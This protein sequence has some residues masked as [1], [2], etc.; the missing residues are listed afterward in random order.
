M[1]GWWLY[2]VTLH[3]WSLACLL[4]PPS[5]LPRSLWLS[6]SV[7]GSEPAKSRLG[8][9]RC[10]GL[11]HREL[12]STETHWL[13]LTLGIW[14]PCSAEY[15]GGIH[16]RFFTSALTFAAAITAIK[17]K[18]NSSGTEVAQICSIY[19]EPRPVGEYLIGHSYTSCKTANYF[20]CC[21]H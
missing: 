1:R 2:R 13:H 3:L 5:S 9:T 15:N 8:L 19:F 12:W 7:T 6:A 20:S 4:S 10:L 11:S 17:Q 21:L 18:K 14:L 16:S